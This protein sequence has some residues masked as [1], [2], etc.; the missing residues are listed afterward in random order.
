MSPTILVVKNAFFESSLSTRRRRGE[1][2]T[3]E[4]E[5]PQ[6][7]ARCAQGCLLG[8]CA[9]REGLSDEDPNSWAPRHSV[10]EDEQAGGDDHDVADGRVRSRVLRRPNR[11]KD[12]QPD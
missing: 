6:P 9:R 3:Y 4:E 12:E 10:A 11:S 1:G 5:V 2:N 8:T 7:V